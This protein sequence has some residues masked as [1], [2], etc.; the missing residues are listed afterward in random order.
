MKFISK[1][2]FITC[3]IAFGC[4]ANESIEPTSILLTYDSSFV[5]AAIQQ[6]RKFLAVE[7]NDEGSLELSG[8]VTKQYSDYLVDVVVAQER[9]YNQSSREI[10]TTILVRE[11]Q[12]GKPI[13]LG[14][15][16][17]EKF[18]FTLK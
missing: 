17:N 13:V 1:V 7:N 10:K 6:D 16:N 18:T 14:S 15:V 9:K 8:L 11:D 2:I 5:L 12:I 3:S 4:V